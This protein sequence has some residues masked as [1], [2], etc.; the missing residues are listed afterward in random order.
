MFMREETFINTQNVIM[1]FVSGM[2]FSL[3]KNNMILFNID[4]YYAIKL[5]MIILTGGILFVFNMF[6]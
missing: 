4:N 6:T 2:V 5:Y 1:I 3:K